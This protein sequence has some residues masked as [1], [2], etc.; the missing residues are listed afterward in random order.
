MGRVLDQ[1]DGL[2]VYSLNLLRGLFE[3][4]YTSRYV[5]LLQT[6]RHQ[7]SFALFDNVETRV[8]P[9]RFKTWWDQV[10]VA[11]VAR[12]IDADLI[13]NPKFSLPL[14]SRRPGVFVLHG[15]DWYVN[16]QHYEW[17]DNLYVRFL[18][19][20]YCRKAKRLLA[21]SQRVLDDLVGFVRLDPAKV[22]VSYA[23][24]SR[25][26]RPPS[27]STE[28][29][30]FRSQ[31]RLPERYIFSVGRTLHTGHGSFPYYPGGNVEGLVRAYEEYRAR[32][33]D[34]ALVIAG[35]NVRGY[36]KAQGVVESK[37]RDI[38]FTGYIPHEEI[39]LAYGLA[40]FFVLTTL[41]ESFSLP[42][43]EA[44][45]CGCPVI[46]PNTGA[47]P[48]VAAGAARLVD[49]QDPSAI[50]EAMTEIS[51]SAALRDELRRLGLERARA[52]SWRAVAECT[53]GVFDEVC[54]LQGRD[55]GNIRPG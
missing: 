38:H 16:P 20:L 46:A 52:F 18:L 47:C 31:Y 54:P 32:G 11:R 48:E 15:S 40:Q 42:L 35:R 44:M 4:D 28:L 49:P 33:G 8:L 3:L 23:A 34:L 17:W 7:S 6:P 22:T 29:V 21:I 2:G 13:F 9:A 41:Y 55:L 19:P 37:L 30:K 45:A 12:Q 10:L 36:L 14:I 24:P 39:H 50:A 1:D 53:L 25:H 43:V 27:Q 51:G 26:F 5:V